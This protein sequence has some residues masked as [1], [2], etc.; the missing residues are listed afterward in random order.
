MVGVQTWI[1]TQSAK[2]EY[3][4]RESLQ[5]FCRGLP[6]RTQE[7]S[8]QCKDIHRDSLFVIFWITNIPSP[9]SMAT[10]SDFS[11]S[12][13][14]RLDGLVSVI[15]GGA[16]G[17]GMM[18]ARTFA[19]NGATVYILGRREDR[20]KQSVESY[21]GDRGSIRPIVCDVTDRSSLLAAA[22]AISKEQKSVHILVNNAGR[23]VRHL[24]G[25][26]AAMQADVNKMRDFLMAEPQSDW[27]D[28][29]NV[30]LTA[31]YF[32]TVAFMPLLA[33]GSA[34]KRYTSQVIFISSVMGTLKVPI[35]SLAY[36]VS[37]AGLNHLSKC[38]GNFLLP[39]NVRTNT[40]A[41]GFFPSEL[42]TLKPSDENGRNSAEDIGP[43]AAAIT[44]AKRIGLEEEIAQTAL[45]MATNQFLLLALMLRPGVRCRAPD[46]CRSD[47]QLDIV[48]RF[49]DVIPLVTCTSKL[50]AVV[51]YLFVC[52]RSSMFTNLILITAV[53]HLID[54]LL[55]FIPTYRGRL[56]LQ[57]FINT[58]L[59]DNWVLTEESRKMMSEN[60]PFTA[61]L[62]Y[63]IV[64]LAVNI[65]MYT[66]VL[67]ETSLVWCSQDFVLLSYSWLIFL[68]YDLTRHMVY[69]YRHTRSLDPL[70]DWCAFGESSVCTGGVITHFASWNSDCSSSWKVECTETNARLVR[71]KSARFIEKQNRDGQ[72]VMCLE[73]KIFDV[74]RNAE[75]EIVMPVPEGMKEKVTYWANEFASGG[76]ITD[77]VW[78]R[79]EKEINF[80]SDSIIISPQ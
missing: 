77:V 47:R 16:T 40:M 4:A 72:P 41:P 15:T 23:G 55:D 10:T 31:G 30:N 21:K 13:L 67:K 22:D 38:L 63:T 78:K 76:F 62:R 73:L 59:R 44:P 7:A 43:L 5:M 51:I 24:A 69:E 39:F 79:Q 1:S 60:R 45:F 19:D 25:I 20:L 65:F 50:T 8:I 58:Q 27:E 54:V 33:A 35:G 37:K 11:A 26:D 53:A 61:T 68:L 12:S 64:A 6:N 36:Q 32:C 28:T 34:E 9:T 57:N 17:L 70:R 71:G 80:P 49:H 18:M 29:L 52:I 3:R 2:S 56:R 46:K 74:Y 42:S 75:R 48:Y 66:L 14:Y